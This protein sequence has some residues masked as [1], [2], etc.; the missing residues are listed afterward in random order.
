MIVLVVFL[1]DMRTKQH[2]SSLRYLSR[3]NAYNLLI[4]LY[5]TFGDIQYVTY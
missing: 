2:L 1:R 5:D 3:I 4:I